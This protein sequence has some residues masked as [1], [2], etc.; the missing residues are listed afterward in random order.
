MSGFLPDLANWA[1]RGGAGDNADNNNNGENE[2]EG[3]GAAV[4]APEPAITEADMR[5]RRLAR[6]EAMQKRQQEAQAQAQQDPQPMEVDTDTKS[7]STTTAATTTTPMEMDSSPPVTKK[8]KGESIPAAAIV[9][10]PTSVKATK[11]K[12]TTPIDPAR[13]IQRKKELLIRKVLNVTI[14]NRQNRDPACL[15][16]DLGLDENNADDNG[17]IGV[18]TIAELL[19]TRLSLPPSQLRETVPT[20]KSFITY[21]ATAHRKAAEEAKTLRQQQKDTNQPLIEILN[22]IQTQVVSY[23]SSGLMEPDLFEQ[24]SDSRSQLLRAM[25]ETCGGGGDPLKSL[26][27]G[28]TGKSDSSFYHQLCDELNTQD[29][30]AFETVIAGIVSCVAKHLKQCDNIDATVTVDVTDTNQDGTTPPTTSTNNERLSCGPTQLL[31]ALSAVCGHKKAA[32]VVTNIS[33]FLL[34]PVG[35]SAA[36]ETIRPPM[37]A[38]A[39]LF[40]MLAGAGGNQRRPYKKRSGVGLEEHTLLG[41]VFKI[42]V[43]RSNNPAFPTGDNILR[44]PASV[45]EQIT[46]SQRQQ[47]KVYQILLNQLVMSFVKAGK[48]TRNALFKWFVD[49]QLVNPAA[50]GMRPDYSTKVSSPSLLLNV[51]VALLKLCEP[52]VSDEKKHSLIDPLF[53]LSDEDNLGVFPGQEA[54]DDALPRLGGDEE[55]DNTTMSTTTPYNPKNTFIPQCFYYAARSISL[56]IAPSL[57]QHE[58][59]LRSINHR[60]WTLNNSNSDLQSDPHFRMMIT[61]QRAAEVTLFQEEMIVDTVQFCDL[62]AKI[63]YET[64]N[65]EILRNMPEF[66]VVNICDILMDVGKFQ[67][68]LLRGLQFPN[69]FKLVVKLLSPKHAHTIRNYNLRAK[70]GDTL[71]ALYLPETKPQHYRDIPQSIALDPTKGGQSYLL[72]DVEAQ[73][74]LAPSLLL[75][76]GEVEH[77]GSYDQKKHRAKIS[78]L[79]KYLWESKEHRPAFQKITQNKDSFIKFANGII[80]ETNQLISTVMEKL[81]KIKTTQEMMANAAE[82]GRLTEEEQSDATSRL[83]DD[84]AEVKSALPLC[85]KTLQMFGYLNTDEVIRGLF[86][87]PELCPR[88][89]NM[90]IH[91]LGKLIGSRGLDLKVRTKFKLL[92]V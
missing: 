78:S 48:D 21:L 15:H 81:P 9:T 75:L 80:N 61:R 22:E 65:D 64:D 7:A 92:H 86:L 19:A 24:A 26:T 18:H 42:S 52:F 2:G 60:H 32:L 25:I 13:K 23:A 62:M 39:D 55:G 34:P 8:A 83:E 90:L 44:Q 56:G 66:F 1:L 50:T 41:T 12:S 47:L 58:N 68:K 17:D 20:Q 85:N 70:L 5:E 63:M 16:I 59:L 53:V 89:V 72:S 74:T 14:Y 36:N 35:S 29:S 51:Q 37:P 11:T 49:F 33:D 79:L 73:E 57:S 71:F 31:A 10:T 91:V 4:A 77:T 69:I 3:E 38:G 82:W 87:L 84:E 27:H 30:T 43:P 28:I 76:Y 45:I 40:R 54:G 6:M 88:L 46:R 67:G